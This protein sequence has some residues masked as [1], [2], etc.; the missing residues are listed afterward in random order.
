MCMGAKGG[1]M[2]GA[3]E[4]WTGAFWLWTTDQRLLGLIN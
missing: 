3:A 4:E 1:G 2:E